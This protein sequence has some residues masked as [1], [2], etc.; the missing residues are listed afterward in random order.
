MDND[1]RHHFEKN[2]TTR[3]VICVALVT[4]IGIALFEYLDP[5][6]ETKHLLLGAIAGATVGFLVGC[7]WRGGR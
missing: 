4:I 3:N 5:S 2:H 6:E 7:L 1:V